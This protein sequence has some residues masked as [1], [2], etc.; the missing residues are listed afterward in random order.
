MSPTPQLTQTTLTERGFRGFV[1]FHELPNSNVP[2][3][4]GIYVVIRTDASPPSFLLTS[5]AGHLKGRDP[6]VSADKLGDAWVDGATVVYIGKAAGQNGLNQRLG[7]Y[8]RHGAGL[9]AGHW[10]GRYIWQLADSGALLVAWRPMTEED[11]SE[12]EQDLIDEFKRLH[13][14]AL[15]FAN[16]RNNGRRVLETDAGVG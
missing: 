6:S 2:T 3:G 11:A 16:L 12:A 1:P 15:P 5:P 13:R 10:G 7:D 9:L 4:H 14:G 8:R